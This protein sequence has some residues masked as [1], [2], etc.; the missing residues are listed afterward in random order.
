MKPAGNVFDD[1]SGVKL[2]YESSEIREGDYWFIGGV[3]WV[4]VG[5]KENHLLIARADKPKLSV[6]LEASDL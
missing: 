5:K 4:V 2:G 6:I 3:K 1:I